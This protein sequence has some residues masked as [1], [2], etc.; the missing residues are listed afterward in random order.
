MK[1]IH[2]ERFGITFVAYVRA[3]RKVTVN[4]SLVGFGEVVTE[5][6]YGGDV[7][8]ASVEKIAVFR[9]GR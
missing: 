5:R 9:T 1:A 7:V 8:S 6:I 4:G 2:V 3:D